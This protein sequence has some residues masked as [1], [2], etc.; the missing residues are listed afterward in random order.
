[1]RVVHAS[2]RVLASSLFKREHLMR[3][4]LL[5]QAAAVLASFGYAFDRLL[6]RHQKI[7]LHTLLSSWW[8]KLDATSIP[9]LVPLVASA[10]IRFLR[11]ITPGRRRSWPR[12]LIWY[13]PVSLAV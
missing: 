6:L 1:M 7:R 3:W 11:H 10:T 4:I 9:D 12:V 5:A 8:Y 2:G 13:I